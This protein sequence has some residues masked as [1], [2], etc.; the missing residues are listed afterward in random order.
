VNGDLPNTI[1]PRRRAAR[2]RGVARRGGWPQGQ[3]LPGGGR[4][5]QC[6]I[7]LSAQTD[8]GATQ[9]EHRRWCADSA[10]AGGP[11]ARDRDRGYERAQILRWRWRGPGERLP[12]ASAGSTCGAMAVGCFGNALVHGARG[13]RPLTAM[14][15]LSTGTSRVLQM[16]AGCFLSTPTPAT[17]ARG[18]LKQASHRQI[19]TRNCTTAA[20]VGRRPG[21]SW[22]RAGW[23][24][25][26]RAYAQARIGALES[27]GRSMRRAGPSSW[28]TAHVDLRSACLHI[29]DHLAAADAALRR[30]RPRRECA[31]LEARARELDRSRG[32]IAQ[33]RSMMA[34]CLG[35]DRMTRLTASNRRA[36]QLDSRTSALQLQGAGDRLQSG[37]DIRLGGT[38]TC[39]R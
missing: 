4:S 22:P 36:S 37:G 17:H 13:P 29:G 2:Q 28:R 19:E 5:P 10:A 12:T 26:V 34:P 9:G 39:G 27:A 15:L 38:S 14:V 23:P 32:P 1:A 18:N 7:G 3:A 31:S 30:S 24:V 33:P 20:A 21:Q 6:P 25:T 8:A 35:F 11:S 16:I